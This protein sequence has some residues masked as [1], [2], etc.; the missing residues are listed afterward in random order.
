MVLQIFA[1]TGFDRH[2][3]PTHFAE[4]HMVV[5]GQVARPRRHRQAMVRTLI[6]EASQ[7]LRVSV[8]TTPAAS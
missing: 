7:N 3:M 1:P 6:D 5:R 2:Y 8:E 4:H